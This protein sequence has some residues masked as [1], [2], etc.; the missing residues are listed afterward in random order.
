MFL[1]SSAMSWEYHTISAS[2]TKTQD[3]ADSPPHPSD[4]DVV[5][6]DSNDADDN[7]ADDNADVDADDDADNSADINAEDGQ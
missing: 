4:A 6:A 2:S 1:L 5:G 3:E 7:N